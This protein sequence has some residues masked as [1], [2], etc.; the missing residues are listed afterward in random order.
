MPFDDRDEVLATVQASTARRIMGM[1]C[2][3]VLGLLLIY[4][5]FAQPP[6]LQWQVFLVVSGAVAL[7][8]TDAMRRATA[9]RIELTPEVLRDADGTLIARIEDIESIDRGAFSFKPSNGFL[10]KLRAP[11]P[12]G[13]RPGLWWRMGRRV[14]IGGMTPGTEGKFMSEAL[15]TLLA[16]RDHRPD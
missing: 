16:E 2:L 15:G 11:A 9:S 4:M 6:A 10:L 12:R 1:G 13:W 3:G 8:A 14:G 7:W 5:A